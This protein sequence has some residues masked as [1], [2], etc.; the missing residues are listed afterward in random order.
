MCTGRGRDERRFHEGFVVGDVPTDRFPHRDA[1]RPTFTG[2]DDGLDRAGHE[3]RGRSV[4]VLVQL[5]CRKLAALVRCGKNELGE[6]SNG[7]TWVY[8]DGPTCSQ[9]A[10]HYVYPRRSS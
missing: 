1:P 9:G 4:V 6:S 5:H 2:L 10:P 3:D 7:L 8:P